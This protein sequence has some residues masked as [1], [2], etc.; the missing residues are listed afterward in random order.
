MGD[1]MGTRYQVIINTSNQLDKEAFQTRIDSVLN[2]FN[3]KMSH[4]IDDSQI[5]I[6]N[7]MRKDVLLDISDD[8][9]HVLEKSFFYNKI[10]KGMFDITILPIYNIW[11]FNGADVINEPNQNQIDSVLAITGMDKLTLHKNNRISKAH[12]NLSIDLGAIAKGY[13]VDILSDFLISNNYN[14]HLVEIGGE[15]KILGDE[16]K[17]WNISIQSPQNY[18]DIIDRININNNSIATS[19]N[20]ANFREYKDSENI[21]THIMNPIT[22]LPLEISDGIVASATVIS[23]NCIDADALAT[24]LMLLN[25]GDAINFIENIDEAE[26]Y[27][28]FFEQDSLNFSETSGFNR[29]RKTN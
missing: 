3:Q 20:Y 8:F 5:S 2:N 23:K 28:V 24:I 18:Y 26:A 10:S 19:G 27:I 9:Y 6:F 12:N 4:Y 16:K 29:F 13:G 22:G 25:K 15:I 17:R 14:S 7:K 21:K 1:T 11:G